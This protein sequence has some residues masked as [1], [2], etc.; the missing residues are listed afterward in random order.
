MRGLGRAAGWT[1]LVLLVAF[2][3]AKF[4]LFEIEE[5]GHDYMAPNILTGDQIAVY[6]RASPERGDVV[7]CEHPREPGRRVIG[8][9]VG[10]AGDEVAIE[11]GALFLNGTAVAVTSPEPDTFRLTGDQELRLVRETLGSGRSWLT[12]VDPAHPVQMREVEV[13]SGWYLLAD[14]RPSGTDSRAFGEVHPSLCKGRAFLLL[15]PGPGQGITS[16]ADRR[17]TW[18]E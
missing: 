7:V 15:L 2:V 1:L 8:R 5:L 16:P 17:F 14:N 3:V 6:T 13:E 18:I 9:L 12:A 10:V 11:R 4:L